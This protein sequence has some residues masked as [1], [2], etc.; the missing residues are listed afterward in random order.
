MSGFMLRV[1]LSLYRVYLY[2]CLVACLRLLLLT[3]GLH[4]GFEG[5]LELDGIVFIFKCLIWF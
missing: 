4:G 5:H 1:V 3:F 2:G